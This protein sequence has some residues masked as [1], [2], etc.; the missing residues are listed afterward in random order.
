[1]HVIHESVGHNLVAALSTDLLVAY[2]RQLLR[3]D[4][5]KTEMCCSREDLHRIIT[6]KTCEHPLDYKTVQHKSANSM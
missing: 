4:E 3:S 5:M 2:I 6:Y 1:M